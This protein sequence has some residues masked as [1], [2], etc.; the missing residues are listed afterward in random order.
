MYMGNVI[1]MWAIG[2]RNRSEKVYNT[3]RNM[4]TFGSKV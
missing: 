1:V 4:T 2:E 3:I